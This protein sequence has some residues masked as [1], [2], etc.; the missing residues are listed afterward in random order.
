MDEAIGP[1]LSVGE[2]VDGEQ[3]LWQVLILQETKSK[4]KPEWKQAT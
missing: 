1:G 3:K 4:G 2:G